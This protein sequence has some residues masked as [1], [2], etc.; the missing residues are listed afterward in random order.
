MG[1]T[2]L[3]PSVAKMGMEDKEAEVAA[4]AVS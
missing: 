3:I 2:R 4:G 1:P